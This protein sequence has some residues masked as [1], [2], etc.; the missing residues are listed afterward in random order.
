MRIDKSTQKRIRDTYS[1]L[2][3]EKRLDYV[4]AMA[5]KYKVPRYD[6][7]LILDGENPG[8]WRAK[9]IKNAPLAC[10]AA[11]LLTITAHAYISAPTVEPLP[12]A[13]PLV[14][15]QPITAP[16][17]PPEPTTVAQEPQAYYPIKE[18]ERR[19]I[20]RVLMSECPYEPAEG[21]KAV[22]QVVLD[23]VRSDDFPNTI[24]EV[25]TQNN[26]FATPSD[27][28]VLPEVA[29]AVAAVFDR[30]ERVSKEEMLYFYAPYYG[31]SEWHENQ[32]F[33]IKIGGLRFFS[34][35]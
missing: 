16:A 4:H 32:E 3:M 1:A 21:Q 33:I 6:I 24:Y 26:Q 25:L 34:G 35:K 5:E 14:I 11:A 18:W 27:A 20:E 30:G 22:A 9:A 29:E 23:R 15:M 13:E 17:E 2:P 12:P 28:E 31:V 19:L 7:R 10:V 8:G